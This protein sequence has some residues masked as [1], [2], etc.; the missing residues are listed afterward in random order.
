MDQME[1]TPRTAEPL[2]IM[3]RTQFVEVIREKRRKETVSIDQVLFLKPKEFVMDQME[4]TPRTVEL[5]DI[6]T[7]TQFAEAIR[8][9]KRKE[10]VLIDQE[11]YLNKWVMKPVFQYIF[12]T[13][14]QTLTDALNPKT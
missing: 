13:E 4:A 11:P 1:A 3:I 12:V 9:K 8:E 2:D 5:L 7:K 10:T 6:M 14:S